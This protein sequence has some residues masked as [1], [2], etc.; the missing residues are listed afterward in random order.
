MCGRFVSASPP[1]QIARYFDAVDDAAERAPRA[2]LQRG[3]RPTTST[4]CS[5]DGGVR[6]LEPLHWGLVPFWAKDPSVGNRMINARAETHRRRRTPTSGPSASGAASSRPTA[7]TSGRT[8]PARRRSSRCTSTAPTASRWPSPGCGRCGA[9]RTHPDER[10]ALVHDHH[11]RA[12]RE[13]GRDP[14]PHAG[15]PAAVG[16]GHAGSTPRSTTSTCWASSW[17]RRRSSLID[18]APGGHRGQQ[19]AQQRTRTSSTRSTRRSRA[20]DVGRC[21]SAGPVLDGHLP[22]ARRQRHPAL[23]GPARQRPGRPPGA[24][25]RGRRAVRRARRPVAGPG[26]VART[27]PPTWPPTRRRRGRSATGSTRS[28]PS[29]PASNVFA[30]Q[31]AFI[32]YP[33]AWLTR[34]RAR[35]SRCCSPCSPRRWRWPSSRSGGC[36]G[37]W[38]RC[39]PAPSLMVLLVYAAHPIDPD[40]QPRRLPPRDPG[41]ARS[42]SAPATSGCPSTGAGSPLCCVI[43]M[44]CRADLGLAVAGLGVLIMVQGHRAPGRDRARRRP[45]VGASASCWWCS[46]TSATACPSC[47]PTPRTATRRGSV[48]WGMLTHPVDAVQPGVLPRRT[49][50]CSCTCSRPVLFLPFL[51]PR[52]LLPVV[53][54]QVLYLAG[55]VT[56]ATRYGPQAVAII[57]FI[58]LATP[59]GLN[60]LGRAERREG[61]HRPAGAHHHGRGRASRSSCS[62]RRARS[63][64][65]RGT[66][67]ARTRPTAPASR[68]PTRSE[69]RRGCGPRTS[70]LV[71]LAERAELYHLDLGRPREPAPDVE[72]VTRGVDAIVDRPPRGVAGQRLPGAHPRGADRPARLHRAVRRRGHRRVHQA[73]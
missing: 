10:A 4:S 59:R 24:L 1:D 5:S 38:R 68:R 28:R 39:A 37:G 9:T 69:R 58:F 47:R 17:C 6:R 55:D 71:Q 11:R 49:S 13:D 31:G 61:Q 34:L 29:P 45:G 19:R 52:Y 7:S 41:A 32:F 35:P 2:E 42:S 21:R 40:P 62:T 54:L 25:G 66:G 18:A 36:V 51:S 48:L 43:A 50:S 57:A 67:A 53:P 44:L 56:M 64:S 26:P 23:A 14:R 8:S 3:A 22:P 15:D 60:R 16:L 73:T 65:D 33:L 46:P 30:P 70:M 12:Q 27:A 20:D 63:T 72:D